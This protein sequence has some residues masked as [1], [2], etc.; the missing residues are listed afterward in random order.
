LESLSYPIYKPT[1]IVPDGIKKLATFKGYTVDLRLQQF[2]KVPLGGIPMKIVT[3]VAIIAKITGFGCII[4]LCASFWFFYGTKNTALGGL[5]MA[6]C[7]PIGLLSLGCTYY[8]KK[9]RREEFINNPTTIHTTGVVIAVRTKYI[10]YDYAPTLHFATVRFHDTNGVVQLVETDN[11]I[12]PTIVGDKVE[13]A[14]APG[15]PKTVII[16]A[17]DTEQGIHYRTNQF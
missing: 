2:R 15:Q 4:C 14:Y 12:V 1:E 9:I 13:L 8:E 16:L 17:K 3:Y 6:L 11:S 7:I 10:P 5:C